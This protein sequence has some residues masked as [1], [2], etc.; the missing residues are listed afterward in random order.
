MIAEVFYAHKKR[1]GGRTD[2]VID[3]VIKDMCDVLKDDN[4]RFDRDKFLEA[5][6]IK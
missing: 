3:E 2:A 1:Y 6:G 5:C 4:Q